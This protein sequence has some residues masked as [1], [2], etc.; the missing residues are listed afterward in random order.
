MKAGEPAPAFV[1]LVNFLGHVAQ[2]YPT[3]F[4]SFVL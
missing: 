1:N 3:V 4:A 2:C